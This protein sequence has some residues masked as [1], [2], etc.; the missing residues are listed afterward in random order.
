MV[1]DSS[2]LLSSDSSG[3]GATL[4][5]FAGDALTGSASSELLMWSS[6]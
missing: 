4:A 6:Y 5:F 1:P 2:S 3:G